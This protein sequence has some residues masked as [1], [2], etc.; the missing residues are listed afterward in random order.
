MRPIILA[1][2]LEGTL[3]SN[4]VSQIPRPGLMEFLN[5]ASS[6]F[7]RIVMFT[8]VP[9][10]VVAEITSLLVL[11]GRAPEWS[12]H[13]PYIEWDGP[14]KDLRFVSAELGEALLLDDHGAYVHPGQHFLW[15]E[16]PL[17]AAPYSDGDEGLQLVIQRLEERLNPGSTK[18]KARP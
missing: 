12:H 14:T 16:A 1:L 10:K 5:Y 11:E 13:L 8:S 7:N 3:I 9:Q 4:A 17:F 2:D 18:P 15:I 6:T